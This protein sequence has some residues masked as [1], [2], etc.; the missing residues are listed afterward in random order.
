V[1]APLGINA[2]DAK[3]AAGRLGFRDHK[4]ASSVEKD[5]ALSMTARPAPD[6]KT[7]KV[8]ILVA[9]GVDLLTFKRLQLDLVEAGAQCKIIAPQL[10]TVTTSSGKQL[11]VDHTFH[12]TASIMFDAVLVPGGAASATALSQTGEAVHFVLE[13]YKHC[14][15]VCALD[16][17]AQLLGTLGFA[18]EEHGDAVMEPTAGVL[19]AD[20]RKAAEGRISQAF[21]AAITAHR[22]WDRLNVDAVPA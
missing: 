15:A 5:D 16:D 14:K 6:I 22:H 9:D 21:I 12:N 17:G 2:P 7:R 1:A 8:A 20:A 13:A 18:L 10:G 4:M 11:A 19:L 3:A